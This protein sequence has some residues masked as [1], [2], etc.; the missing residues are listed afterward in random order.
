MLAFL[1]PTHRSI[2]HLNEAIHTDTLLP[3]VED[4]VEYRLATGTTSL[5]AIATP[6]ITAVGHNICPML[7]KAIKTWATVLR[8]ILS[9]HTGIAHHTDSSGLALLQLEAIHTGDW[10]GEA[11]WRT[12][13]VVEANLASAGSIDIQE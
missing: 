1:A 8:I 5:I 6:F 2:V 11:R 3:F 7:S 13:M 9:I 12:I 10:A 4:A